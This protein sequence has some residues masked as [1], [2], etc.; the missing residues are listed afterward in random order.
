[1][2]IGLDRGTARRIFAACDQ[3]ENEGRINLDQFQKLVM[4]K[5]SET[6]DQ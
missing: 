4:R 3:I 5:Q 6:I 2:Q 1:M